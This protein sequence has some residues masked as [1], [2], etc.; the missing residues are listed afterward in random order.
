MVAFIEILPP[1]EKE[2]KLV[3]APQLGQADVKQP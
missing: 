1:H 3:A 2:N